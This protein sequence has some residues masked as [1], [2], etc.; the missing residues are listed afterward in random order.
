MKILKKKNIYFDFV[1]PYFSK[2]RK[3]RKISIEKKSIKLNTRNSKNYDC[4]I[5]VTDHDKFNYNFI[6]KNFRY[7][8]DTR[9]VFFR[10][11]IIS[12]PIDKPTPLLKTITHITRI[13]RNDKKELMK[14]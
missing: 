10:K 6:K 8:F 3:G 9:G 4:A 14:F 1:D 2:I 11:K 12:K 13:K 5:I 7:V